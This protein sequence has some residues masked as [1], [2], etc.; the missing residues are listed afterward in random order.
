MDN[1][2]DYSL[3]N[4]SFKNDTRTNFQKVVDWNKTFGV[5]VNDKPKLDIFDD[6]ALVN[7]RLALIEEEVSELKTA[8]EERNMEEVYDA[9]SDIL[10]VVYGAGATFGLDLDK[11]MHFVNE[12]NLSKSCSTEKQ[13]QDTVKWY[14]ENEDR[15]DSPIYEKSDNG[16]YWI[17][18]NESTKK[19]LKCIDWK[20]VNFKELIDQQL[21]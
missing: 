16:D 7:Y 1:Y 8:I 19:I 11:G 14:K 6:T 3:A 10:V 21:K 12:S 18:K 20:T 13:A 9:L 2:L 17:V 15:Y 5:V 4:D